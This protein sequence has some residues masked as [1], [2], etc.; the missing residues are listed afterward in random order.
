M[1]RRVFAAVLASAGI[2]ACGHGSHSAEPAPIPIP[3]ATGPNTLTAAERHD[4]W[5]L[6]FDGRTLTGWH[7]Y[8]QSLGVTRGW[9]VEDGAIA[10]VDSLGDLVSDQQFSNFEL[11]LEWKVSRG[12]NSGI[13][14]WANEGTQYVYMNAAE[15]QVLDN[16]NFKPDGD[17]PLEQAGALYDLYPVP[18]GTPVKPAGEWNQV[19]IIAHGSKVQLWLN[20]VRTVD[21]NFDSDEMLKKIKNS[22]FNAWQSF[23]K[24]RRGHIALQDHS[25]KVWFRNIKIK[26]NDR[27]Y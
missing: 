12:A 25:G 7:T 11:D 18:Q 23:A 4:G 14:W 8:Q 3:E 9:A 15:M 19:R 6:L 17:K 10:R 1:T 20:G 22:K 5:Q 27:S 26:S 16:A 2:A 13:F 24:S 21:V